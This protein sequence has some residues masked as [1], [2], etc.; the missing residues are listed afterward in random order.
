MPWEF[1]DYVAGVG[2]VRRL[3]SIGI[4]RVFFKVEKDVAMARPLSD[5]LRAYG[6]VIPGWL[7]DICNEDPGRNV[8]PGTQDPPTADQSTPTHDGK[9]EWTQEL[10]TGDNVAGWVKPIRLHTRHH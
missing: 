2:R 3:G 9:A 7:Q 4:A 5:H 10:A 8:A 1:D 6:Q